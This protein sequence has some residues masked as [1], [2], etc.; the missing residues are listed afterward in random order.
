VNCIDRY[1]WSPS[2]QG[3]IKSFVS[4]RHFSS[5]G[6]LGNSKS[7]VVTTVYCRLSGLMEGGGDVRIIEKHG[8][9]E[10]YVLYIDLSLS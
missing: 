6:R 4:P 9:S 8:Q 3:R 10:L 1:I 2:S 7:I 5:L